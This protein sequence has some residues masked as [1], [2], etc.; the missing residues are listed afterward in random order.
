MLAPF[1]ASKSLTCDA[2]RSPERG[3]LDLSFYMYAWSHS[4]C[5][6]SDQEGKKQGLSF[7]RRNWQ[8]HKT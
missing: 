4:Y 3:G 8:E 5:V 2:T 6:L 1:A 7:F